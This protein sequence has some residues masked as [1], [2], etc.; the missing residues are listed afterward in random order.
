MAGNPDK[1]GR[2]GRE[3]QMGRRRYT[4]VPGYHSV[5]PRVF[6]FRVWTSTE[7]AHQLVN[8]LQAVDRT[9]FALTEHASSIDGHVHLWL[10]QEN[11]EYLENLGMTG[12]NMEATTS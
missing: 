12:S 4:K 7:H 6:P 10:S 3:Y 5:L 9:G 1:A 11:A 8:E 2:T